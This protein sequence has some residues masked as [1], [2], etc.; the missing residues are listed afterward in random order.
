[1]EKLTLK[2]LLEKQVWLISV[3]KW[4]NMLFIGT[5][6]EAEQTRNDKGRWEASNSTKKLLESGMKRIIIDDGDG[7]TSLDNFIERFII[8]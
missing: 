5:E 7:T 8:K 1:M 2:E 4:G 3:E 6:K